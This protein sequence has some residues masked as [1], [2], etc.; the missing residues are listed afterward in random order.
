MSIYV[1]DQEYIDKTLNKG[2]SFM[3]TLEDI[4]IDNS[5][6]RHSDRY[7]LDLFRVK[8]THINNLYNR[9]MH[10]DNCNYVS[11][12]NVN[13]YNDDSSSGDNDNIDT[14]YET[15]KRITIRDINHDIEIID[16]NIDCIDIRDSILNRIDIINTKC[17]YLDIDNCV[18]DSIYID[19]SSINNIKVNN[20]IFKGAFAIRYDSDINN[21]IFNNSLVNNTEALF[22]NHVYIDK[23]NEFKYKYIEN[24]YKG[25]YEE[26]VQDIA[27]NRLVINNS[28]II[29][30]NLDKES[31]KILTSSIKE[32][33]NNNLLVTNNDKNN[34]NSS[35]KDNSICIDNADIICGCYDSEDI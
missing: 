11:I 19:N 33:I 5:I 32:D 16:S 1:I 9:N 14:N 7:S 23:C 35:D 31:H 18:G 29:N 8:L 22:D 34:N 17:K 4:N 3:F 24:A 6:Q 26:K 12:N 20:V 21:I 27:N 15:N 28:C 30:N 2:V 10:I 13:I 25:L